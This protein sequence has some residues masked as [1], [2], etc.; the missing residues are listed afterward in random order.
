MRKTYALIVVTVLIGLTPLVRADLV[1]A[2]QLKKI[3]KIFKQAQESSDLYHSVVQLNAEKAPAPAM[4]P[5][6]KHF[7]FYWRWI[8]GEKWQLVRAEINATRGTASSHHKYLFDDRG[9]LIFVYR[10]FPDLPTVAQP[11]PP[12]VEERLYFYDE[13]LFRYQKATRVLAADTQEANMIE[14]EVEAEAARVKKAFEAM[15]EA[16]R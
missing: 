13:I 8:P 2:T 11:D 3:K 4:G 9:R 12:D 1:E 6:D 15:S 14:D 16:A 5:F 7:D 10:K